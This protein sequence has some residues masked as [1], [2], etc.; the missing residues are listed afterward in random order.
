[1]MEEQK[2]VYFDDPNLTNPRSPFS[3]SLNFEMGVKS[4]LNVNKNMNQYAQL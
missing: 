4:A 2:F 1:M 3:S